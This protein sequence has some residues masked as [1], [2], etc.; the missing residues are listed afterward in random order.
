MLPITVRGVNIG[1][2]SG[3]SDA[4]LSY[5]PAALRLLDAVPLRSSDWVRTRDDAAGTLTLAVGTLA[6]DEQAMIQVRFLI[7]QNNSTTIRLVRDDA[8]DRANPLFLDLAHVTE[9]PIPLTVQQIGSTITITGRGYKPG[10]TLVLWANTRQGS[11]IAIDETF[12]AM[13]DED[14][15][16]DLLLPVPEPDVASIVVRGDMSDVL[17]VAEVGSETG[18]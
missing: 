17:G 10:E 4:I 12:T 7:Q 1:N 8:R 5:D 14:G 13:N 6:P 2:G 9:D 18:E 11:V 15:S 16:I 3:R